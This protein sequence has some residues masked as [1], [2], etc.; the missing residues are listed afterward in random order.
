MADSETAM[1]EK[2]GAVVFDMTAVAE[3]SGEKRVR[4][5]LVKS[6]QIDAEIACYENGQPTPLHAHPRQDEI[7]YIVQGRAN[8]NIGGVEHALPAGSMVRCDHGLPHDVRNLGPERCVVAFFKLNVM[9][10]DAV[11]PTAPAKPRPARPGA[12]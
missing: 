3:F 7:F 4:K 2:R 8:M 1:E 9:L 12:N 11:M 10:V 5:A 6:G